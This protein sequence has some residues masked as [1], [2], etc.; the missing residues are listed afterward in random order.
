M[1]GRLAS[2]ILKKAGLGEFVAASEDEYVALA[3][4][5]GRDEDYRRQVRAR[6]QASRDIL[7]QDNTLIK[8]FED[9][10]IQVTNR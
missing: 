2:G 7:Y 1:R 8:A 6:I 5:L 3:V 10:L 4:N 9:F